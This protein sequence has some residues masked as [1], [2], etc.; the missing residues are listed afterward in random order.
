MFAGDGLGATEWVATTECLTW[1]FDDWPN[2]WLRFGT[3]D[4]GI[5]CRDKNDKKWCTLTEGS[6]QLL[7]WPGDTSMVVRALPKTTG[8]CNL[9]PFR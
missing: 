7:K 4:K 9:A 8:S 3:E 2:E 5:V 1:C 6:Y